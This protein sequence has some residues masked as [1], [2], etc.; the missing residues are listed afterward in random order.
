MMTWTRGQCYNMAMLILAVTYAIS[1]FQGAP[2]AN[3]A[4]S[5]C[6]SAFDLSMLFAYMAISA[7]CL[8]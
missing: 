1:Y 6:M 4:A 7:V 8:R 5:A 2:H 3:D